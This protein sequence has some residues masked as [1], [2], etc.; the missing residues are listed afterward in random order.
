MYCDACGTALQP[1][2]GFCGKC[3]KEIRPGLSIAYPRPNRVREHVRLVGILWLAYSAFHL[4]GGIVLW[5]LSNTI[6]A[7]NHEFGGPRGPAF[8]HTLFVMLGLLLLAK[9]IAG[10]LG[11][12]GLLQR[13]P[14]GRVLILIVAFI[15]LLDVPIG[16]GL[17][18]YTLW[19]LLPADSEQQYVEQT[20]EWRAA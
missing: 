2:Q 11:G 1:G 6:F 16:T 20:A 15:G 17:G 8:L 4:I 14:W 19:V 3:G 13:E 18:V 5:I 12:W 9:S 7:R 10:F